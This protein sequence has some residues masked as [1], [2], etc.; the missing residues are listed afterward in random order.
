MKKKGTKKQISLHCVDGA[1]GKE[2][3]K[4]AGEFLSLHIR[5]FAMRLG[6]ALLNNI[7]NPIRSKVALLG[8]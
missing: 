3:I 2:K 4:P 7:S 6:F 5:A 1:D 8:V